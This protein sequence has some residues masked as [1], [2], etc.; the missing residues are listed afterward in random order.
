MLNVSVSLISDVIGTDIQS[1]AFVYGVYSLLDKF[2]NGFLLWYLV[3]YYSTDIIALKYILA[4]S[5]SLS[6]I[7]CALFTG[8]GV[9]LYYD[10]LVHPTSNIEKDYY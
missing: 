2:A 4:I 3:T 5:P 7:G 10:K 1:S 8:I 6:A 9:T